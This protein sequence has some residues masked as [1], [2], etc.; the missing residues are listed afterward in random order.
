MSIFPIQGAAALV[1]S[2]APLKAASNVVSTTGNAFAALFKRTVAPSHK[3]EEKEQTKDASSTSQSG[4]MVNGINVA[5][6]R[7]DNAASIDDFAAKFRKLLKEAGIEPVGGIELQLNNMG[8]VQ[9]VGNPLEKTKIESLLS[10]HP[11]LGNQF[12][13]IAA[14]SGLLQALEESA[15]C[16]KA[17]GSNASQSL[18]ADLPGLLSRGPAPKFTLNVLPDRAEA[19]LSAQ[20]PSL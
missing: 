2:G 3:S 6:L 12:R 1:T 4:A 18:T 9:V 15:R 14:N 11:E 7:K 20:S 8:Q 13:Q 5:Q 16:Q 17:D 10:Q 19:S